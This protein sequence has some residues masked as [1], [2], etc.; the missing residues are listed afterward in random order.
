MPHH[1]INAEK[2]R[3]V[4]GL[5]KPWENNLRFFLTHFLQI[6]TKRCPVCFLCET[7]IQNLKYAKTDHFGD[8]FV[9]EGGIFTNKNAQKKSL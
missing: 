6:F 1:G 3:T 2:V 8:N 9:K 7:A 4:F 5:G